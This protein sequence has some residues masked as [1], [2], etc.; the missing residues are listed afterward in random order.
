MRLLAPLADFQP[1]QHELERGSACGLLLHPP[2]SLVHPARLGEQDGVVQPLSQPS[3]KRVGWVG[4]S[5]DLAGTFRP[6]C[7]CGSVCSVRPTRCSRSGK[8]YSVF[9]VGLVNGLGRPIHR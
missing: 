2:F 8:G 7:C 5:P 9:R 1:P 6:F 4:I 3:R